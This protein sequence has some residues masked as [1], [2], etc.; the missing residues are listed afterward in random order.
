MRSSVSAAE[1]YINTKKAKK[2]KLPVPNPPSFSPS[3]YI[4][5]KLC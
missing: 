2:N 5:G 3:K 4:E 1:E